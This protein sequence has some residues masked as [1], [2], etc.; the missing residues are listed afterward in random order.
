M[1]R[2]CSNWHADNCIIHADVRDY[3]HE[4][5]NGQTNEKTAKIPDKTIL[6]QHKKKLYTQ[7]KL[8]VIFSEIN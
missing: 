3:I 4:K 7:R 6:H 5:G 1:Q 8:T 2:P